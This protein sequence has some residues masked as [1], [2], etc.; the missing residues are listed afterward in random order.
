[1]TRGGGGL[2]LHP[3]SPPVSFCFPPLPPLL[4]RFPRTTPFEVS[5]STHPVSSYVR[6]SGRTGASRRA[7]TSPV[8]EEGPETLVPFRGTEARRA[9]R[10]P[11]PKSFPSFLPTPE[12][13]RPTCFLGHGWTSRPRPLLVLTAEAGDTGRK[14]WV[15]R[16]V[17][18][19]PP[20][21]RCR[22]KINVSRVS[23]TTP[24]SCL[25]SPRL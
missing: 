17:A 18:S 25:E 19:V 7:G 14:S 24:T 10:V 21:V 23:C 15:G 6:T 2:L 20:R 5:S 11:V 13:R 22:G 3:P 16:G 12:T 1:M 8:T 4:L 9:V